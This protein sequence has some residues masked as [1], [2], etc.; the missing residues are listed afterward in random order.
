MTTMLLRCV[1]QKVPI[2][3]VSLK[4]FKDTKC[5]VYRKRP[6]HSNVRSSCV[7]EKSTLWPWKWTFK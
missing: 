2:T 6:C 3:V 4:V 7:R 1:I 5:T